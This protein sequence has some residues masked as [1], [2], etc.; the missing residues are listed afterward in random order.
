LTTVNL[1][2]P[3][4][5]GAILVGA[6]LMELNLSQANLKEADLT[7]A[8][9]SGADLSGA[10]LSFA[11]LQDADLN[12]SGMAGA[13]FTG[14][15]MVRASLKGANLSGARLDHAQLDRADLGNANLSRTIMRRA[16]MRRAVLSGANLSGSELLE[17]QMEGADLGGAVLEGARITRGEARSRCAVCGMPLEADGGCDS[18]KKQETGALLLS[19]SS[20]PIY[21]TLFLSLVAGPLNFAVMPLMAAAAGE[22]DVLRLGLL[23]GMGLSALAL[24]IGMIT[25]RRSEGREKRLFVV[26]TFLSA[27]NLAAL[28][29]LGGAL[30]L[31]GFALIGGWW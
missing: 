6:K 10:D 1:A 12:R 24:L 19:R 14:A 17:V 8:N 28:G 31:G 27:F 11:R 18:C 29:L 9:L 15:V 22:P 3:D 20:W 2:Q 21:F 4:L 25:S 7:S 26:N 30:Q 23:A 16:S 5:E 13:N